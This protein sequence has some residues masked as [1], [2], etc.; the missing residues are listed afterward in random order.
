M[1]VSNRFTWH[2]WFRIKVLLVA[3]MLHSI[4]KCSMSVSSKSFDQVFQDKLAVNNSFY[5]SL[6][7]AI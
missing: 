7:I 4:F 3:E 1:V 2:C 5:H 6:F